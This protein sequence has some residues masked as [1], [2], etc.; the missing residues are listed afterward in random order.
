MLYYLHLCGVKLLANKTAHYHKHH[1]H[2]I[3]LLVGYATY[4]IVDGTY[5]WMTNAQL[6]HQNYTLLDRRAK[7]QDRLVILI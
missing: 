5:Y 6:F 7:V 1:Y 3:R 4:N 2:N